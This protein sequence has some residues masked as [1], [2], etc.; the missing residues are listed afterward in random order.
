MSRV[1]LRGTPASPG[2]AIG[3]AWRRGEGVS[4]ADVAVDR[5]RERDIALAALA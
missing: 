2:V 4:G 1:L 5:E 3:D